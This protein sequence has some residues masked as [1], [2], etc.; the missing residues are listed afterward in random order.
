MKIIVEGKMRE[1]K[2]TIIEIIAD[3][4]LKHGFE[5]KLDEFEMRT[6]SPQRCKFLQERIKEIQAHCATIDIEAK[7]ISRFQKREII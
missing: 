6:N 5:I 7:Q 4:L 1:G 3:A 2:S